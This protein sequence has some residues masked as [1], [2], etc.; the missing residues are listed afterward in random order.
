MPPNHLPQRSAKSIPVER[1][2]DPI[3]NHSSVGEAI[4]KY[5]YDGPKARLSE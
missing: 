1:T 4:G 5:L 2:L 3:C